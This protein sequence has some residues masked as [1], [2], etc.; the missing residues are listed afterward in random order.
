MDEKGFAIG[1]INKTSRVVNIKMLKQGRIKGA[2]QDGNRSWVLIIASI[3]ADG[4]YL[5][6]GVIFKGSGGLQESWVNDFDPD[7]ETAY[8]YS[9][10]SGYTNEEIAYL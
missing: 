4:T 3:C 8:F 5:P 9:T 7:D 1:V 10:P 6:C 2:G